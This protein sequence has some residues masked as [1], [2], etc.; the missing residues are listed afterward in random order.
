MLK[1]LLSAMVT[2]GKGVT[3][4]LDIPLG[5]DVVSGFPHREYDGKQYSGFVKGHGVVLL[6]DDLE[7]L[8]LVRALS[9]KGLFWCQRER[10]RSKVQ[11]FV[12]GHAALEAMLAPFS[13]LM[14]KALLLHTDTAH[15]RLTADQLDTLLAAEIRRGL[16]RLAPLPLL[17]VPGMCAQAERE[18]FFETASYFR[19][20]RVK[21]PKAGLPEIVSLSLAQAFANC[22]A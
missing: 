12:F 9:W 11:T 10:F 20:R 18:Q 15:V 4:G 7:L 2:A 13:G 5:E 22:K 8:Q 6:T 1:R 14:G 19:T 3:A 21:P 16:A 17:G